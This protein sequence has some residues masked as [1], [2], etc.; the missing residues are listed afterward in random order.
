MAADSPRAA[1]APAADAAPA[2]AEPPASETWI[3]H[4][5]GEDSIV[6][7]LQC[8][9]RG[10][11]RTIEDLCKLCIDANASDIVAAL[12]PEGLMPFSNNYGYVFRY[13]DMNKRQLA[14][15]V[16]VVDSM[17]VRNRMMKCVHENN[18]YIVPLDP[19]FKKIADAVLLFGAASFLSQC[20]AQ[21]VV[22]GDGSTYSQRLP[23]FEQERLVNAAIFRIVNSSVMSR[24]TLKECMHM[25]AAH[26]VSL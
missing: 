6:H 4:F 20:L 7:T 8:L 24:G 10:G 21:T 15:L 1:A 17:T 26:N 19:D 5:F 16:A 2:A 9:L 14:A 25:L 3:A 22:G 11:G 13:E 23:A 18:F 12:T